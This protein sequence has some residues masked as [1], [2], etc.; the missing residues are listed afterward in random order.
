MLVQGSWYIGTASSCSPRSYQMGAAPAVAKGVCARGVRAHTRLSLSRARALPLFLSFSSFS[1]TP[2]LS[3]A[4]FPH[5]HTH[6]QLHRKRSLLHP[7]GQLERRYA[8]TVCIH[9]PR[10]GHL[11]RSRYL[12]EPKKTY[13][14]RSLLETYLEKSLLARYPS[15]HTPVDLPMYTPSHAYQPSAVHQAFISTGA[16]LAAGR[17]SV[18]VAFPTADGAEPLGRWP[19]GDDGFVTALDDS[20]DRHRRYEVFY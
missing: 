2:S 18:E 15:E 3:H 8:R 7:P 9:Q 5:T 13:V 14:E 16:H 10:F 19:V 20:D 12:S 6:T 4:P 11:H 1:L 17:H